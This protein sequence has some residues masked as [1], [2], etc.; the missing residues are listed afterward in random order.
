MADRQRVSFRTTDVSSVP[1][2]AVSEVVEMSGPN[3]THRAACFNVCTGDIEDAPGLDSLW[4][5]AA[6]ERDGKIVVK[7]SEKEVKSKVGRV[8][9]KS[10][11]VKDHTKESVVII[12]G[13]AGGSHTIESL[14]MVSGDGYEV[15]WHGSWVERLPRRYRPHLRGDLPAH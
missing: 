11:T 8:V 6:A 1:G 10:R 14:R 2:T 15:V 13:G 12:G 3:E 4:S 7:A 9:P 5:F